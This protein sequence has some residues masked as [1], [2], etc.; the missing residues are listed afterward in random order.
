MK[1]K[2]LLPI[3]AMLILASCRKEQDLIMQPT[4][5]Q[6][7]TGWGNTNKGSGTNEDF[8]SGTKGSY[9]AANVT[10]STGSWYFDDA[11]LGSLGT[12]HKVGTKA[13]RMINTGSISMNFN[14]SGISRV[15]IQHA[16]FGSDGSSKWQLFASDNNGV[17][18]V[19]VS[20]T[21]TTSSATLTTDSFTLNVSG[22]VRIMIKKLT[23]G[24]NRLN[25]DEVFFENFVTPS[26][27]DHMLI[28]NPSHAAFTTDSF[29][30]YLMDKSF[31]KLSYNK[32]R[33]TPNWV[34]WH[35]YQND[36]DTTD[37]LNN[38]RQD[39]SL[40]AGWYR[41]G[42]T[43]YSG[44][45]FDRGH[46]CP[47]AD[48]TLSYASNSSTFLMT[49]M[50]PQA[51]Y[52]NQ[53]TWG[54]MEDYIRTQIN[55]GK[56]AYVIMGS[57]G[58]GGTGANGYATT[59]NSGKITVPSS[60]W[61]VVILLPNGNTDLARIDTSTRIIAVDVPNNNSVNSNWKNYRTNIASIEA[62]TGY[63]ILENVSVLIKNYLKGKIDN[64]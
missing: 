47:S 62:A 26:D 27:N 24:G 20:D 52:H 34:S 37:R 38:F 2:H 5:D 18:F 32:T 8:E 44:S 25:F 60:I 3:I 6:N 50:I 43:S 63:D 33:A 21:I 36:L 13:V 51:P 58:I 56:E 46:N 7:P 14:M 11:L 1:T 29:N 22:N 10:L 48:R 40:P 53:Q 64:L 35:L 45:G 31:F 57:Y 41:V 4:V 42:S 54:N 61:K 15:F 39:S 30:N 55:T 9:A 12:D 59:I 16:V 28:G 23:G 49:N 19:A 17:S